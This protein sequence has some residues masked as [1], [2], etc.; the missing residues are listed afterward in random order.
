MSFNTN[1]L[2]SAAP[3]DKL[4][5]ATLRLSDGTSSSTP[6]ATPTHYRCVCPATL[7]KT[8]S[9]NR[10]HGTP[11]TACFTLGK[12]NIDTKDRPA[13]RKGA[14]VWECTFEHA[15]LADAALLVEGI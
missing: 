9:G 6:A 10:C 7:P 15:H 14:Q 5:Q 1:A 12:Y 2:W 3:D 4:D 8:F 11:G 13:L